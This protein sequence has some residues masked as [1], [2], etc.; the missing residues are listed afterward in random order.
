[1]KFA[2]FVVADSYNMENTCCGSK[3]TTCLT[4]AIIILTVVIIG[5]AIALGMV[6]HKS[7]TH[8]DEHHKNDV[9][10]NISFWV[11]QRMRNS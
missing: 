5:L 2:F 4:I 10:T 3:R 8:H 1:M 6:T 9:S 11:E 7:V